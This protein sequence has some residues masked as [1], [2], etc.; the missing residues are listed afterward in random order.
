MLH[1]MAWQAA[2]AGQAA[3]LVRQLAGTGPV[4]W[5]CPAAAAR[6]P[7]MPGSDCSPAFAAPFLWATGKRAAGQL[8]GPLPYVTKPKSTDCKQ[9]L[10]EVQRQAAALTILSTGVVAA[11]GVSRKD[12]L[13]DGNH[14]IISGAIWD[15]WSVDI[16]AP[17]W[18]HSRHNRLHSGRR[19][20]GTSKSCMP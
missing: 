8:R 9:A 17:I 19:R 20:S 4:A 1:S 13:A 14:C 12:F 11:V 7:Q 3:H 15:V 6:H 10:K 16:A 5:L 18:A 2:E